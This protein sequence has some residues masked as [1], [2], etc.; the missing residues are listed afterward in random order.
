MGYLRLA[1]DVH[2]LHMIFCGS[3]EFHQ[4][5]LTRRARVSHSANVDNT[6]PAPSPREWPFARAVKVRYEDRI[7]LVTA[8]A[9]YSVLDDVTWF[10]QAGPRTESGQS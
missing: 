7:R 10:V 5:C 6:A 4:A 9:H 1:S 2:V 8:G 3:V